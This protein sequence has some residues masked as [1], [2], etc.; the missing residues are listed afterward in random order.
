MSQWSARIF[1]SRPYPNRLIDMFTGIIT[2]VGAIAS[3]RE[4]GGDVRVRIEC[5]ELKPQR[6]ATGESICVSGVCL[7]ALDID[8]KGFSADVSRETLNVT[9]FSSWQAGSKV[10]LEPSLAIGDR[11]GGHLVTGHTD[12]VGILQARQDDARS[13]RMRFAV[14]DA[15]A[16]YIAKK[17]SVCVDGTS[18][19]VNEAEGPTFEVNI[20]PH[21]ASETTLGLLAVGDQV[22]IEV[23]LLARYAERL[24]GGD[25]AADS[26]LDQAFL[27]RTG[28]SD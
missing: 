24:L 3:L 7:T 10:N 14:P 17:G 9:A 28:F 27:A 12:G 22:N 13:V 25:T 11:L 26:K 4:Q 20:I 8:E 15:L 23:D 19:T 6:F 5:A 21:T 18:L 16:R 1:A 2:A